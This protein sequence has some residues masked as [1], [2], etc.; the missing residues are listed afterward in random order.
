MKLL[1]YCGNALVIIFIVLISI[2]FMNLISA[3]MLLRLGRRK[4]EETS[5]ENYFQPVVNFAGSCA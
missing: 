5:S 4:E 1:S 3:V 2:L